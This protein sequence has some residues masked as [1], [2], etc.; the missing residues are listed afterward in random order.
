MPL[1]KRCNC[2]LPP[3]Y[4]QVISNSEPMEDGEYPKE[5]IFCIRQTS[6]V[7]RETEK[8]SGKYVEYSKNDCIKDYKEFIDKIRRSRKLQDIFNKT[9]NMGFV[10]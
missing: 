6:Y 4:V 1:C 2:Y 7:E 10:K 8:G 5:C 9:N 3:N